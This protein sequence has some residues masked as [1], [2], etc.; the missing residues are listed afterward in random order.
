MAA[1]NPKKHIRVAGYFENLV[2]VYP[3]GAGGG[4]E[5]KQQNRNIHGNRILNL[6]EQVRNEFAVSSEVE[7]PVD[8]VRD[9]A[10]YVDFTSEWGYPLKLDSLDQDK[11]SFQLLNIREE[12]RKE[13]D[14]TLS[15]SHVTLMMREGGISTF[16]K[17][18]NEYLSKSFKITSA[19]L[20][21]N[22]V[23]EFRN[24]RMICNSFFIHLCL[25]Y[26][27]TFL[28]LFQV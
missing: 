7:L 21:V 8:I 23:V 16:I 19:K 20:G 3:G 2:Y 6:L 11:G 13:G 28:I 12:I 22:S 26:F 18:V 10:I 4:I 1:N 9:D 15:R 5:V 25:V 17:K 27:D 14:D 24:N